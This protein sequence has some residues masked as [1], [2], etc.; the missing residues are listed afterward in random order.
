MIKITRDMLREK[1]ACTS[2]YR[3]FCKEFSDD[4]YPDGVG[5]QDLLDICAENGRGAYASWLIDA[6]GHTTD[7]RKIE[8]DYISEKSIY[9][10]G[11]LEVTGKIYCRGN[12]KAGWGIKAGESIEAGFGIKAGKSIKAGWGIKA[13]ESIKAGKSI[14]AGFGIKAGLGIEA[15]ESIE[16]GW[17]IEAGESIKAGNDWGIY[18]GTHAKISSDLRRVVAKT[19]PR[20]LMSGEFLELKE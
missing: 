9:V 6:F 2:G 7:V 3:E 17:G 5:Y 4:E 11:R 16:A 20:N 1:G 8:G 12:I 10:C 13:G 18:A 15:G 14:E 19:R